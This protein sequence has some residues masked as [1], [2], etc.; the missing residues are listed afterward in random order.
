MRTFKELFKVAK[1]RIGWKIELKGALVEVY[2]EEIRDLLLEGGDK[3]PKLTVRQGKEGN[4]VPGLTIQPVAS[5]EDVD[6]LLETGQKNRTTAATDMNL[7]SSRSH[8][9]VQ[10][11]GSMTTPDGKTTNSVITLVDLAGSER[12][13]KSG[14]TGDRAKEA[15]AINKSLSALG[16]VINSRATK[17]AHTPYR[18]SMLTH[19]LQDSLGGDSKTLMLMQVNPCCDH[20]EETMCSLQ[21]GAR[22]NNVEMSSKK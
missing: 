17:N 2:N 15:I 12:I 6:A 16:D 5:P 1:E 7:H 11:H 18:N 14:V 10:I 9:L 21:F 3:R 8:L 22:V 19:L 13:A 20:I 4:F